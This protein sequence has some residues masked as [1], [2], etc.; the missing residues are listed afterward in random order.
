MGWTQKIWITVTNGVF[1][2]VL[3]VSIDVGKETNLLISVI[4][5]IIFNIGED[6][7]DICIKIS[8]FGVLFRS[9]KEL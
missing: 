3:D 6:N 5:F 9:R 4:N 2:V 8:I 7:K 1:S